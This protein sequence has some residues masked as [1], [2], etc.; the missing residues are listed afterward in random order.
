MSK[1]NVN[2]CFGTLNV[3]T[4]PYVPKA[5][6]KSYNRVFMCVSVLNSSYVVS[7]MK[8]L[9]ISIIFSQPVS[10]VFRRWKLYRVDSGKIQIGWG[11]YSLRSDLVVSV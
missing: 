11:L 1:G 3:R 5:K 7:V 10:H 8:D 9:P 6:N 2:F 4:F